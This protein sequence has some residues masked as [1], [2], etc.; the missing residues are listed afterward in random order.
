MNFLFTAVLL[1]IAGYVLYGAITAKGKLFAVDNIKEEKVSQFKKL[2]RPIYA[3]WGV[4]MFLMALTSAYQNIVYA[5][6][7]YEFTNDFKSIFAEQISADGTIQGTDGN[8]N[9]T[10]SYTKMSSIFSNLEQPTIPD[11]VQVTYVSPV[12]DENGQYVFLG[13]GENSVN[14]NTTYAKLRSV[15]SYQASQI[16]TW[17][18]MGLAI[19]IVIGLFILINRFTDKEKLAKARAKAAS[20]GSMPSSAFDFEEESSNNNETES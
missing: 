10:Y 17:V 11:G 6:P 15:I 3:A 4:L 13:L 19:V 16:L 12:T 9:E 14:E 20:G 5:D 1:A 7:A 8:V 2:L 18:L